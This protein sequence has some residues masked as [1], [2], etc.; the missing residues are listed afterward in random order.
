[1]VVN[2]TQEELEKEVWKDIVN[3]EDLY[4]I[5]NLGRIQRTGKQTEVGGFY[6]KYKQKILKPRFDKNGYTSVILSKLGKTKT[7]KIHRCVLSTF[8][9]LSELQVD[10]INGIKCDNR[11][12]NLRYCTNRENIHFYRDIKNTNIPI[13][14]HLNKS[15]KWVASI[16]IDNI[17]YY[18][19]IYKIVSEAEI[20]YNNALNNWITNG[21]LPSKKTI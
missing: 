18:L 13:G 4:Q 20:V 1:M 21:V 5:S 2:Y 8:E 14:V 12:I 19:G 17:Y 9:R 15:F 11:L 16:K 6:R 7:I 3:Y 10:H